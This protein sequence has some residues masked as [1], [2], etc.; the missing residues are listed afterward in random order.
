MT[1][2]LPPSIVAYLAEREQIRVDR[3]NATIH[4]MTQQEARLVME[5]A[6]MAYVRGANFGRA[7]GKIPKDLAIVS[8]VIDACLSMP[9]LYPV[10]SSLTERDESPGS[11]ATD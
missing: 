2:A 4:A 5:A 7:G 3:M 11:T 1:E 8:E 10:M 6:V 9:D